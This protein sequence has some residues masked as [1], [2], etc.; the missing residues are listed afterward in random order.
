MFLTFR[1]LSDYYCVCEAHVWVPEYSTGQSFPSTLASRDQL[2]S[3]GLR[4]F[5]HLPPLQPLVCSMEGPFTLTSQTNKQT[6]PRMC[7]QAICVCSFS[8]KIHAEMYVPE[9]MDSEMHT[10]SYTYIFIY[11]HAHTHITHLHRTHIHTQISTCQHSHIH[12]S[13]YSHIQISHTHSL[14]FTCTHP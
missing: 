5:S 3:P 4:A 13:T 12:T 6:N 8:Q 1:K 11:T 2:G 7:F 14:S 10:H 9:F